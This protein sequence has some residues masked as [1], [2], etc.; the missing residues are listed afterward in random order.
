M[1]KDLVTSLQGKQE[2]CIHLLY[3]TLVGQYEYTTQPKSSYWYHVIDTKG[4]VL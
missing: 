2:L 3:E 4:A 1:P